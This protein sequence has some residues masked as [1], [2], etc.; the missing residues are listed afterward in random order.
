MDQQQQ[1]LHKSILNGLARVANPHRHYGAERHKLLIFALCRP[2]VDRHS[3]DHLV[4][5]LD[6]QHNSGCGEVVVV[7]ELEL[8]AVRL[9]PT[10]GNPSD[11]DGVG[12]VR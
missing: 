12:G 2:P 10:L 6:N 4:N 8:E 9:L 3:L 11:G 5:F 1:E 7:T